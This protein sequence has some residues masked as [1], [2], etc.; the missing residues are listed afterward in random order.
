MLEQDHLPW[1]TQIAAE[2][3][4]ARWPAFRADGSPYPAGELPLARGLRGDVVAQE[5]IRSATERV[6]S[7]TAGPIR[8]ESGKT[9]AAVVA[10]VDISER[11]RAEKERELFVGALG[12][13]L[14]NP[15]QAISLTATALTR[16]NDFPDMA[17]KAVARIASSA[18]RLNGLIRELLDFATSQHG[19]IPIKPEKCELNEIA[20][21]V[22]AEI[23]LARPDRDIRVE[24]QGACDGQIDR[25]RM[26]Q[27]FQNLLVNAV[28]HGDPGAPITV[29][30]GCGND[31]VWAAV[32]NRGAIPPEERRGI[33]EPFRR[34]ATSKG[35]GLGLYIARALVEAHGGTI[36]VECPDDET[37]F[38]IK[39]P[40]RPAH[41]GRPQARTAADFH[42]V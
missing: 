22:I 7:V 42:E 36:A 2:G 33:F 17:K 41:P 18:N 5:E 1:G 19:A 15:V 9:I 16:R 23:K 40:V 35:L 10:L 34:R 38:L 37:V 8:D 30:T 3:D 28:E 13:D 39:L 31:E 4:Y 27:V 12:H 11:K 14:R 6:Y 21:D 29:R 26:A 25:G 20:A 32:T 24:P